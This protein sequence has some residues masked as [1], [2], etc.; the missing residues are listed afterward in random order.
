MA[1]VT[2]WYS[3]VDA[4]SREQDQSNSA[5]SDDNAAPSIFSFCATYFSR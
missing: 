5:E 3:A 2:L 4:G 1:F